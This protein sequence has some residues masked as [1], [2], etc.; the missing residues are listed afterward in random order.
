VVIKL[1]VK[2]PKEKEA[3]LE[4]PGAEE[5]LASL[6]GDASG[7]PFYAI[8][9][10]KGKKIADSNALSGNR[11]IGYP[12]NPAEIAAFRKLLQETAPRLTAEQLDRITTYLNGAGAH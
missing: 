1:D 2:E 12:A 3:L 5:I 7:L 10:E 4:N 11:N 6:G 8:L 9:D